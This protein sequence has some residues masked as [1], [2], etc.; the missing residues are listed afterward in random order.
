MHTE[1]PYLLREGRVKK[2]IREAEGVFTFYIETPIKAFPGQYNMLYAFG[3]G[4]APITIAHA[5]NGH[6]I[7]TVRAVGDVTKHIDTLK[8]GDILYYRGPYGNTWDIE[9]AYGKHLLIVSGGLGLA[10]TRWIYEKALKEAS[11][12]KKLVHLY[13]AKDYDSL[14]YR[15]LYQQ[16]GMGENFLITL[17]K[18][19]ER[20]KGP[21]GL[22]TELLKMVNVEPDTV[23]FMCGPD[24]MVKA[25]IAEL[26]KRGVSVRNI[27][28]SL[29][30]HMKCSVGTCGHCMIGPFFVCKDGPIFRYD[31]IREFFERKE[32]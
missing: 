28:V 26:E 25:F 7:H 31:R 14:I 10:A 8:E 29:E 20:W 5:E 4:E 12:F 15:Y 16:W 23:V 27:Y 22:I 13:G 11:A 32:V 21:K 30:R 19:D 2:V 24:P 17:D 9:S 3:M 1:N 6:L 18:P